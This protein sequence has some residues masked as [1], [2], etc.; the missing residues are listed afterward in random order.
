MEQALFDTV[1]VELRAGEAPADSRGA[2]AFRA[3]GSTLIEAGF[4]AADTQSFDT[5]SG[6]AD[7]DDDKGL[8]A[9]EAGERVKR[10][11]RITDPHFSEAAPRYNE[12]SR[13]KPRE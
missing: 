9:L 12:A 3:S 8:Q 2:H 5:Q 13:V 11:D 7:D 6:K 10:T 1:T 4:I